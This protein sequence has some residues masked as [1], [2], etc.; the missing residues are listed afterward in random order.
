[1]RIA[2]TDFRKNGYHY[3]QLARV[4]DVALYCQGGGAAY[5]VVVIRRHSGFVL[6]GKQVE[7]AEYLPCNEEWGR[8]GWT[9][10]TKSEAEA[11]MATVL[12]T[13]EQKA[14]NRAI[15]HGAGPSCGEFRSALTPADEQNAELTAH[16]TKCGA[17]LNQTEA[18]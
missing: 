1:M 7:P 16:P 9:L 11:K 13:L 15:Q 3:V 6:A 10:H 12:A 8:Y 2:P 18:A 17:T 5:E 14:E 4:G